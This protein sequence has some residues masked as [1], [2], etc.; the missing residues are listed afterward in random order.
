MELDLAGTYKYLGEIINEKTNLKDQIT[1]IE[2]KLEAAYQTVLAIAGGPPLQEHKNGNNM[3]A[4]HHM[5]DTNHHLR[6]GNKET[7]QNGKEKT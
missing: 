5:P 7:H 4:G 3:E 1:Q 2:R 6:R